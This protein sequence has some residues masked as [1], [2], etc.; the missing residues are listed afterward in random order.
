VTLPPAAAREWRQFRLLSRDR[1]RAMLNA[2]LFSRDADPV[3]FALWIGAIVTTI[4]FLFAVKQT[5]AYAMLR[6]A[7]PETVAIVLTSHRLFFVAYAMLAAAL[8][9]ALTWEAVFPSDEDVDVLG[10]LPVHP[11]TIAA[12][13]L[14][15]ATVGVVVFAAGTAVPSAFIFALVAGSRVADLGGAPAIPRAFAGHMIATTTGALLVFSTLLTLRA[16]VACGA[17]AR[18]A[19]KLGTV[20]QLVTIVALAGVLFFL[21]GIVFRLG[22]QIMLGE[23]PD[24]AAPAAWA[25]ALYVVI[26]GGAPAFLVPEAMRAVLALMAA[27]VVVAVSYLAPASYLR[28]RAA[29]VRER[30][31]ADHVAAAARVLARTTLRSAVSR[32]V[33][34]FI[35]T[36]LSRSRP[37]AL[38]LATYAGLAVAFVMMTLVVTVV[39][40][41][42]WPEAPTRAMAAL[43]LFAM[44]FMVVGLRSAFNVP[45]DLTANW[46]FRLNDPGTRRATNATRAAFVAFGVIP[47]VLLGMPLGALLGWAAADVGRLAL[48]QVAWGLLLVEGVLYRWTKTPFTCAHVADPETVRSGWLRGAAW[49]FAFAFAGAAMQTAALRA[50]AVA[51]CLM[52][53]LGAAIS[54]HLARRRVDSLMTLEYEPP[55]GELE[56]LNLSEALR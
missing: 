55:H 47:P 25:T 10:P 9:A 32:A 23:A 33:F 12:A 18:M 48:L 4:P 6:G 38:V 41:G 15:A 2:A 42:S 17:G 27:A 19:L 13:H 26:G 29:E 16:L 34:V 1:L 31:R 40:H 28:R 54:V 7:P 30:A 11:R 52:L 44:F 20:L 37:H 53:V 24:I 14:A 8:V 3:L 46:T 5:M 39:R 21:P 50:E 43:P 56:T 45:T 51:G 36:S 35:V 49:L 22:P